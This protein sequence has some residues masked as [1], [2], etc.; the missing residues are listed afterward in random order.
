MSFSWRQYWADRS[1]GGHRSQAEEF[2]R[3]EAREKL[4]HLGSGSSLLD[5]GCGAADLLVYYAE[6][7]ERVVGVDFSQ[8]MLDAAR[9]RAERFGRTN[10][11]LVC[12]DDAAVW[13][14]VEGSF[15]RISA[16]QVIQYFDEAQ[17]DGFLAGAKRA[18]A[19]GGEIILFD[20]IDP[21]IYVL[22]ELGLFGGNRGVRLVRHAAQLLASKTVRRLRR[23]PDSIIGYRHAPERIGAVAGRHGFAMELV[24][25]MYYEYRY[26]ALLR[27]TDR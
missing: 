9:E 27:R 2:L 22:H 26:H 24:W 13:D 7:F 5:F 19:R 23:L 3:K 20:V 1:D 14:V 16:G 10:I 18:L 8:T 17:I 11:E 25:S 6:H 15:D 4:F 21:R 12:A